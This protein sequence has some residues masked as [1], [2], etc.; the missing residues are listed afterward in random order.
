[1]LCTRIIKHKVF[2]AFFFVSKLV[3]VVTS[4]AYAGVTTDG[5]APH[6]WTVELLTVYTLR[7]NLHSVA[8]HS[9]DGALCVQFVAVQKDCQCFSGHGSLLTKTRLT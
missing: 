6:P 5:S 3:A 4:K 2:L 9:H 1:M 7:V 8:H